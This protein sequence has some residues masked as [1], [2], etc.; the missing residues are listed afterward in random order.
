MMSMSRQPGKLR[1]VVKVGGSLFD[2][3][4]LGDRLNRLTAQLPKQLVFVPGGGKLIDAIRELDRI[5]EIGDRGSHLIALQALSVTAE[6]LGQIVPRPTIVYHL[7]S[8]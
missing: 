2:L 8:C 4:D 7:A 3:P 1:T 6:I 5:H